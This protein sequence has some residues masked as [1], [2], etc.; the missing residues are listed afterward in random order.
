M[1]AGE[2]SSVVGDDGVGDPD[3]T[4][5]V[6]PEELDNL[7]PANLRKR[8]RLDS[9]GEVVGAY[10]EKTTEIMLEGAVQLRPALIA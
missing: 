7:L 9:F 10:L 6:L 2:I 8:H 1:L 3:V 5:F 4:Y